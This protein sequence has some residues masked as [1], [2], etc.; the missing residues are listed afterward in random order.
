[1][2]GKDRECIVQGQRRTGRGQSNHE[3]KGHRVF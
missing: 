1:V 2:R 3:P